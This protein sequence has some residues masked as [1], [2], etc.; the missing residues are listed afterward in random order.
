MR[1]T[2]CNTISVG[3]AQLNCVFWSVHKSRHRQL[4]IILK[5]QLLMKL[6]SW[7]PQGKQILCIWPETF[8]RRHC[9]QIFCIVRSWKHWGGMPHLTNGQSPVLEIRKVIVLLS[10]LSSSLTRKSI[11]DQTSNMAVKDSVVW[12]CV[13]E[14]KELLILCYG[15]CFNYLLQ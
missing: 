3:C 9:S 6:L 13:K 11:T 8:Y 7:S 4:P 10:Y 12:C 15:W 2:E 5:C 14:M 1:W